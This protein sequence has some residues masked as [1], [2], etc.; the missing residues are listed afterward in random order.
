[1]EHA[2]AL[3]SLYVAAES[4]I[5]EQSS[6]DRATRRPSTWQ[7]PRSTTAGTASPPTPWPRAAPVSTNYFNYFVRTE[8]DRPLAPDLE[9]G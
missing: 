4:N 9:H 8:L 5:A 2:P 7:L 6:L 3:L 1:M